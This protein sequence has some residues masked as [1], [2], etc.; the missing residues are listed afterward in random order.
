MKSLLRYLEPLVERNTNARIA[1]AMYVMETNTAG[2]V[3]RS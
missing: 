3:V 1:G 2:G